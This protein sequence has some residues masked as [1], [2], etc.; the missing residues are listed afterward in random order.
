MSADPASF[1][2]PDIACLSPDRIDNVARAVLSLTRE[3]VV[4]TDR[5]LVLEQVLESRGIPVADAVERHQ[6]DAA[7]QA[8]I[9]TAAAAIIDSVV[10]ALRGT[11]GSR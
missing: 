5:V 11:D 9:D 6:P 2:L 7:L 8:R 10:A 4:L 3:L 1:N